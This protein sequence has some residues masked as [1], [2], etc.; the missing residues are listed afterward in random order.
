MPSPLTDLPPLDRAAQKTYERALDLLSRCARST[1]HLTASLLQKGEP[2][3]QVEVVVARLC[4]NGLLDDGRYAEAR[5]R[6]GIVGKA[7][8]RR[9]AVE[10]LVHHGVAREVAEAAIRRV[11]EEE[12]IDEEAVALRAA[13]KKMRALA[14]LDAEARRQ[15]LYA[16][17]ARQGY[18]AEV[19]RRTLRAVLDVAPPDEAGE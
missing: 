19:V 7:R 13:E 9:R 11:L 2:A 5:A 15:K 8:S 18:G 4:A 1:R 12:G 16:F 17:L 14:S 6:A 3:A 10:D